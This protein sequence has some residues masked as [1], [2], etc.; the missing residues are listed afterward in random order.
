MVWFWLV[1]VSYSKTGKGK[2]KNLELVKKVGE[3][4]W[5]H[6]QNWKLTFPKYQTL[7]KATDESGI[8]NPVAR[9]WDCFLEEE[10]FFCSP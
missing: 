9:V 2:S 10:S 8:T 3:R 6:Y 4:I 1:S 7:E 5:L